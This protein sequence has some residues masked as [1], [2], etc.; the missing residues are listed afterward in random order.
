[1]G[2]NGTLGGVDRIRGSLRGVVGE[3]ETVEDLGHEA[4]EVCGWQGNACEGQ[5]VEGKCLRRPMV[6]LAKAMA[7]EEYRK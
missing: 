6:T 1:L 2:V 7:S 4:L 3:E 5:G